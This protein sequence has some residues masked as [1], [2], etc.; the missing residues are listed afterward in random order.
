MS[1][2]PLPC[3]WLQDVTSSIILHIKLIVTEEIIK[4]YQP[5]KVRMPESKEED[6][7]MYTWAIHN[8]WFH[9]CPSCEK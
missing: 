8:K 2:I 7:D 4:C 5:P 6:F 1:Y 9:K 3:D